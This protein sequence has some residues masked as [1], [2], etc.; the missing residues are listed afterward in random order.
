MTEKFF[1]ILKI[2]AGQAGGLLNAKEI[3]KTLEID[4]R[5][6]EK[7]LYVMQK[8]YSIALVRPFWSN[9]RAELTKMPKIFFFDL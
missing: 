8:S 4:V 2:L 1:A 5:T 9:I 3:S 6:V 7:Y